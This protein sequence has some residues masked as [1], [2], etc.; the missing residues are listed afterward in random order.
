MLSR[1]DSWGRSTEGVHRGFRAKGTVLDREGC[2]RDLGVCEGS[3]SED[4]EDTC[5]A[6]VCGAFVLTDAGG[7]EGFEMSGGDMS[8]ESLVRCRDRSITE[9][10]SSKEKEVGS[11]W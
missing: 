1:S 7:E 3:G 11:G 2:E 8:V 5:L 9:S 10:V 4:G 6:G